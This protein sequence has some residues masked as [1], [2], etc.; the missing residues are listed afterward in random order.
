MRHSK[1]INDVRESGLRREF[2]KSVLSESH[3]RHRERK[4][5]FVRGWQA[6]FS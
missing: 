6:V 3:S 4:V 1:L 2:Y 5:C